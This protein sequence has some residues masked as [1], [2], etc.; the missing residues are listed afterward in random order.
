MAAWR[1][2]GP[3]GYPAW[4]VSEMMID[5]RA[6]EIRYRHLRGITRGMDVS[7]RLASTGGAVEVALVHRW[8]GPAW[9]FGPLVAAGMIGPVFV[10]G[11]ASRTLAGIK[12]HAEAA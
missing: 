6:L 2:F 3:I 8:A 12:R 7:W 5:E 4:W 11:I 9:P 1:P 10:H